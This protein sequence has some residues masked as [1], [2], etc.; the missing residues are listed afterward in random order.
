MGIDPLMD[1]AVPSETRQSLS[2][3]EFVISISSFATDSLLELSDVILPMALYAENEGC[4]VNATGIVQ[5]FNSVIKPFGESRPAWKILRVL[6]SRLSLSGFDAIEVADVLGDSLH[7]WMAREFVA[8]ECD[9]GETAA[10]LDTDGLEMIVEIPMY[11]GDSLVRHADSLQKTLEIKKVVRICSDT[12]SSLSLVD[13]ERVTVRLGDRAALAEVILDD[14]IAP[15]AVHVLG[16]CPELLDVLDNCAQV[17][18][19]K[20]LIGAS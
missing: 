15:G 11:R 4:F 14:A 3:A 6:G 1:T 19:E 10:V 12:A 2:E 16:A 5:N 8:P 13:G 18:L 9:K 17:S 7:N 20:T